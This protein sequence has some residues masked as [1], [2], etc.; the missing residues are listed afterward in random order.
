MHSIRISAA[1]LRPLTPALLA[2]FVT[3]AGCAVTAFLSAPAR[4]DVAPQSTLADQRSIFADWALRLTRAPDNMGLDMAVPT[5]RID[6][7]IPAPHLPVSAQWARVMASDPAGIFATPCRGDAELCATPLRSLFD[8]AQ[9]YYAGRAYAAVELID[10]INRRVNAVVRYRDDRVLYGVEDYWASPGET[11]KHGA[12]DCEDIA[13]VKMWLLAAF[14]VAPS[15]MQVTVVRD[16]RNNRGHAV[17]KVVTGETRLVLDN[18]HDEV[19]P[20]S[21]VPWY[22]P[23]YAVTVDG[24]FMFGTM[25]KLALATVDG[26]DARPVLRG[27]L[28]VR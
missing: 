5:D 19:K 20:D 14:G 11:A 23:V 16:A 4:S 25:P 1:A 2:A 8:E 21:A 28:P 22:R 7:P 26:I 12:G 24:S 27:S 18:L 13:I 6:V 10:D 17:L 9:T 3:V 15:S